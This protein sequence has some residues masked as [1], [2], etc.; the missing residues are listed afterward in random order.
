MPTPIT[1]ISKPSAEQYK[2][3]RKLFLVPIYFLG[4][5]APEEG[6]RLLDQY[7]LEVTDHIRNLERTLGKVS[8]VYHETVFGEGDAGMAILESLNPKALPFIRVMCVSGAKLEATD[9]RELFEESTDW[10]R[11]ISIG[12]MSAKVTDIAMQ[13]FRDASDGRYAHIGRCIDET[14]GEGQ[15]AVLFIRPDHRVQFKD[16]VKVFYVSPPSQNA[17]TRW[18]DDQ[19]RLARQSLEQENEESKKTDNGNA[20]DSGAGDSS[21][22]QEESN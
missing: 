20:S 21:N 9:S 6:D 3:N 17:F 11:C 2:D 10:Q 12:L 16:D 18:L 15:V 13:S 1:R 14:L 5:E 7:W 4:P 22:G 19:M 8:H